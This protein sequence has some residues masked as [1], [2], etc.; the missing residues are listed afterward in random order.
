MDLIVVVIGAGDNVTEAEVFCSMLWNVK[1]WVLDLEVSLDKG[2][3]DVGEGE[4]ERLE[5]GSHR[6][7]YNPHQFLYSLSTAKALPR[8]D[9]DSQVHSASE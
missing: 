2:L 4:E 5:V 7:D 8:F 6:E 3:R 9:S 1:F